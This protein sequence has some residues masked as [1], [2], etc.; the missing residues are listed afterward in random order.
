MLIDRSYFIGG[1][2][3]PNS[4]D[5]SVG[6]L[7]DW[8]IEKHEPE[9][10]DCLL[11]YELYKALKAGLQVVT[12]EQRWIDLVQ[13]VE[14]SYQSRTYKWRGLVSQP[15]TVLN[16]LDALNTIEVTVGGAGAYDPASAQNQ[17]TIPASLVG[18]DFILEQRG[19]GQLSTS[20]YSIVGNILTLTTGTFAVNDKFFYKSAT[21]AINTSTGVSKQSLIANYVYYHFMANNYTQTASMGEVKTA[22][23]NSIPINPGLKMSRA[24]NEMSKWAYELHRYLLATQDTYPEWKNQGYYFFMTYDWWYGYNYQSG[25]NKF[26][27]INTL[28]V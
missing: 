4:G 23:E 6:E 15:P 2:N 21:L 9:F 28:N 22:N 8:F 10:L 18:K 27:P 17:A 26:Q 16:A 24:W 20:E 25:Y 7:I 5:T 19:V 12:P 13:G 1:L 3:I 14:Y 11:S